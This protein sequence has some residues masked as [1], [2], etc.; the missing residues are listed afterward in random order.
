MK[1][2]DSLLYIFKPLPLESGDFENKFDIPCSGEFYARN[3]LP[4]VFV[5]V[6]DD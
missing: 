6:W 3:V 2:W 4:V 5:F 1:G